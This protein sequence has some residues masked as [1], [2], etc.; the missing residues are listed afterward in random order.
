[1]TTKRWLV[2]TP[3]YEYMDVIVDGQGPTFWEADVIEIEA[4]TSRDAIALGVKEMLR[5][6]RTKGY[7]WCHDQQLDRCS[8]YT[9]V[10][11]YSA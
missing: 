6:G 9:G 1:M 5:Y 7:R 11:A 4:Q 10:K 8:P 2:V 3:Q